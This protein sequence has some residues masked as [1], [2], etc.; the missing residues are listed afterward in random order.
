MR[1]QV[2]HDE[3]VRALGAFIEAYEEQHG[4]ITD[5][6]IASAKRRAHERA[7]IVR[8]RPARRKTRG[9]KARRSA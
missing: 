3:R 8:G 1:R 2:E 7:V 6:E 5:A 9:V 4:V